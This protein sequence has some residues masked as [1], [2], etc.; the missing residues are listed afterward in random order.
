MP[1]PD[2][3]MQNTLPPVRLVRRTVTFTRFELGVRV[4]EMLL[5]APATPV[6]C[7]IS[8]VVQ[9]GPIFPL[10]EVVDVSTAWT[11]V[12][13]VIVPVRPDILREVRK[14]IGFLGSNRKVSTFGA[15]GTR[16]L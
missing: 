13:G 8:S 1:P 2:D 7:P 4:I 9:R 16:L 11:G 15:S 6:L 5:R 3:E 14:G 12:G 10:S